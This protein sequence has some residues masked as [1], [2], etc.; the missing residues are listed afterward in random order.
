VTRG[1]INANARPY[2][3]YLALT[4]RLR[5]D[6]GWLGIGVLKPFL[7][8]DQL[9]LP[10]R[11]QAEVLQDQL[12][13]LGP[14]G[15]DQN[16]HLP[17]GLI[18]IVLHR[19]DPDVHAITSDEVDE[20]RHAIRALE[21]IPT[22]DQ[23]IDPDR[24]RTIKA[25]RGTAAFRVG[26]ALFHAAITDRPPA[27]QEP[28]RPPTLS[29]KPR[30]NALLERYLSERALVLRPETMSSERGGLR[31][32][33]LWLDTER[34]NID[35]LDQLQRT[36][37]VAFLESVKRLRKLKAP[38]EPLSPAYQTG[39]ISV[40]AVFFRHG[41]LAEWDDMPSRPLITHADMPRGIQKVPRFIPNHQLEP[42]MDQIRALVCPLQ[43]C[44]LLVA[45]WSG[46][47]RSEIRKLQ[48]DCLDTYPDGTP[49]LRL[50]AGKA[51]KRARRP[52]PRGSGRRH[53]ESDRH[54]AST[55]RPRAL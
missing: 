28:K 35:R 39:I 15:L 30:I 5:L 2:L 11:R 6:W 53:R 38:D 8:A 45:R 21:R 10:L 32:F 16:F 18:R 40:V 36:D 17:W 33:G 43:R 4:G 54:A 46:A 42:V 19:G 50:A 34:P 55:G 13:R 51:L 44:A 31:R 49:R 47:R 26:T 24:L 52:D 37:L 29:S 7:V 23:V 41:A 22:I 48:L 14:I 9:G 3:V 1:W 25:N 12:T 27:R 20:L